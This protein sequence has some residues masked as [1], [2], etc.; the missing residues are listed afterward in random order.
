MNDRLKI[1]RPYRTKRGKCR[2]TGER[3]TR[4]EFI[5]LLSMVEILSNDVERDAVMA[6][7]RDIHAGRI[8]TLAEIEADLAEQ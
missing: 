8:R 7:V 2:T 1:R 6:G 3:K 5:S 4:T